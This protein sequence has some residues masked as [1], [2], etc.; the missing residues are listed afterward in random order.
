MGKKEETELLQITLHYRC[1]CGAEVIGVADPRRFTAIVQECGMCGDH[2][3]I[4]V[5]AKC[6]ECGHWNTITIR[7]W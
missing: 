3:D 4:R 7:D 6:S 1:K 2:G 5:D